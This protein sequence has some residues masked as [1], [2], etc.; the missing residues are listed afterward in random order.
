VRSASLIAL[1]V[2]SVATPATARAQAPEAPPP[3]LYGREVVSVSYTSDGPADRDRVKQLIEIPTGRPLTEEA[4]GATIRNLFATR[5]FADVQIEAIPA[6]DGVAVI[7]HLFRAFVIK[8][9]K[10]SGHLG[11]SREELRRALPFGEGSVFEAS[12]IEDGAAALKR[13]LQRD[14]LLQARVSPD[15]SLDRAT[16]QAAVVYRVE[17]GPRARVARFFFDGDTA[18]FTSQEL[19]SR[20]RLKP[21]DRY[22]EEKAPTGRGPSS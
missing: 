17:A 3:P 7:V 21:G 20:A 11:L 15:V 6:G 4:T 14:G 10:L 18:P 8:P 12:Q 22:R 9:L 19:A 1:A 13:R 5:Q 16:F 2:I